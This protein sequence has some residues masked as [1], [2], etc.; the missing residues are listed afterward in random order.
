M[1]LLAGESY[2]RERERNE[3]AESTARLHRRHWALETGVPWP[4]HRLPHISLSLL[5]LFLLIINMFSQSKGM[6]HPHQCFKVISSFT[7]RLIIRRAPYSPSLSRPETSCAVYRVS[8]ELC[9]FDVSWKGH[10]AGLV[11]TLNVFGSRATSKPQQ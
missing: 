10:V 7:L 3:Q 6:Q 11:C 4:S 1:V 9:H 2:L 5:F 8:G